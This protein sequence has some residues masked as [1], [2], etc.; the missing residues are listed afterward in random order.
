MLTIQII[1][2]IIYI[3]T[4]ILKGVIELQVY[5][6]VRAYIDEYGIEQNAVAK[7]CNISASTFSAILNGKRKM[8]AEDF[9]ITTDEN[10][11]KAENA[12]RKCINKEITEEQLD[13]YLETLK[14]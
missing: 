2:Y 9:G 8:Y 1:C 13:K 4:D 12:I 7:K 11:K 14:G 6:K 5:E 10:I 3:I